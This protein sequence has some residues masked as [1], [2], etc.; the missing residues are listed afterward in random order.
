MKKLPTFS[1]WR[2]DRETFRG[3][4]DNPQ[5]YISGNPRYGKTPNKLAGKRDQS[6]A[7]IKDKDRK[8]NFDQNRR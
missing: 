6:R 4:R 7:K 5:G 1:E 8:D 2:K 3:Q